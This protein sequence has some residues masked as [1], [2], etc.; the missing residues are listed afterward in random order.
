MKLSDA[1]SPAGGILVPPPLVRGDT[2]GIVAASGPAD[3]E[4]LAAGMDYLRGIGLRTVPGCFVN[5]C[6]GYLAGTDHQRCQDLNSMPADPQI[7]AVL[8]ARGG[9]GA[10]RLLDSVDYAALAAHPKLLLGM[11]DVTAL[12]LALF[13][14][15]GLV[16]LAGP[17][18][19]GQV[20]QG[21][22]ALSEEWFLKALFEPLSGRDLWPRGN[23]LRIVR[24]G[25]ARGMLLGGCLSL[26][27][28]LLGTRYC[29]DYTGAV[30]ILEEVNEAPYRLDRMLTHLKLS[31]VL[32]K[33]NGL[34]LG[35]FLGPDSTSLIHEAER[36]A[37]EFTAN[38]AVPVV[39]GYPHGH[40]LPNLTIPI[41]V[42]VEMDT[43]DMRLV[44]A[45]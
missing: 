21:L 30:L 37:L 32:E 19:A 45:C 42:P 15:C 1:S 25:R 33:I 3:P 6:E 35:H 7:R 10:M 12:Q 4:L 11:S 16:T 31:G 28:S 13:A 41:G 24:P 8:F 36:I 34:V 40:T 18:V 27:T 22:D 20:G 9:Y 17:M 29:P 5:E 38:A 14:R 26:V 39:S 2:V 44:V 43:E 23:Q